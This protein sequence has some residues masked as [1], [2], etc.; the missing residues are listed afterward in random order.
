MSEAR[1][2]ARRIGKGLEAE[3]ESEGLGREVCIAWEKGCHG[4]ELGSQREGWAG[5]EGFVMGT[6]LAVQ[7]GVMDSGKWGLQQSQQGPPSPLSPP[8][9]QQPDVLGQ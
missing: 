4:T 5:G 9:A 8:T 2:G 1:N 7:P 6:G 3:R